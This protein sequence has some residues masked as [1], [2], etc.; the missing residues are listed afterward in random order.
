ML[1]VCLRFLL[2]SAS[3]PLG[4]C[5]VETIFCCPEKPEALQGQPFF[6]FLNHPRGLAISLGLSQAGLVFL[7]AL[8]LH[9]QKDQR[10]FSHACIF[11]D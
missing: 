11:K 5:A 2:L 6:L 8:Y 10:P 3:L 9:M 4:C 1:A 7:S